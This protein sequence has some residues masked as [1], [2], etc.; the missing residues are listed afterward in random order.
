MFKFFLEN[1]FIAG[2]VFPQYT[3]C[4]GKKFFAFPQET[5]R[6]ICILIANSLFCPYFSVPKT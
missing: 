5:C 3:E 2:I 1:I 4:K 6:N